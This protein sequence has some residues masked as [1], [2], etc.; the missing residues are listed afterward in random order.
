VTTVNEKQEKGE[1]VMS[2]IKIFD[3]TLRDGE[4]SPGC[5]MNINEKIELAKMLEKLNVDVIEAGFA[6]SSNGD[7]ES[8]KAVAGAVTTPI[9]CSLA[10]TKTEDIDRA[11]EALQNAKHPRIHTFI[12]TSPI[13]MEYK[14]KMTPEQVIEKAITA[15]K[16]A[17]EKSDQIE[18]EFSAEDAGRSD[19]DF[20][21]K[22]FT[23]AI[24]AGATIINVPDTVGYTIPGEFGKII[25][26]LKEN[27]PNIDKA[28]ISVHCHN[29]LGLAVANSLIAVE[30]GAAQI[31]ATINGIGERAGN[32]ALEEITMALKTRN[33][34][35]GK[36][37]TTQINTNFLYPA[38]RLLT[39]ITGV[40]VQPNKAI[41]GANAFAHEA[42]IH[43]DGVL[44]HRSTY[45]IM[46]AKDIGMVDNKLVMGKHSGRH[47]FV[48]KLKEL[49]YGDIDKERMEHLF[50]KFKKIA[51]K[52][53]NVTERDI[54]A[55]ASEELKYTEN[56]IYQLEHLYLKT[57]HNIEPTAMMKV[58][59]QN[60]TTIEETLSGNGPVDAIFKTIDKIVH[61]EQLKI[62]LLDYIVHAVT[63]GTDALGE[64]T[65][66]IQRETSI[67]TGYG[68]DTDV[69]VA[70]A[71]AYL[72]AINKSLDFDNKRLNK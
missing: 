15:I 55:L 43:Q 20:L 41:V 45:E 14:L 48:D 31:E 5:S 7:F 39:S 3:T 71:E 57:G 50:I 35:Y 66:R 1:V 2:H 27:I 59:Y 6:I 70:S 25:K 60:K 68:A 61:K 53:K 62:E 28:E 30:N 38:S 44:K 56:R 34:Y 69:M 10:R 36:E 12:A 47:A 16:Y 19:L 40:Q 24:D 11:W 65:V 9:V 33:D 26:H 72:D 42:G 64:V 32:A 49:G 54:M 52:K 13:H 63:H 18:I 4:Q 67:F 58:L 37:K 51:D 29:D 23:A 8:V 17:K 46:S 21:V 22:I